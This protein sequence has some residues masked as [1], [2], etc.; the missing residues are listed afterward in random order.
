MMKRYF[1]YLIDLLI[2][3]SAHVK[4]GLYTARVSKAHLSKII[5]MNAMFK[6][7]Q[8]AVFIEK[9]INFCQPNHIWQHTADF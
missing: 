1:L 5:S 2:L 7:F 4:V 9:R 8:G 3:K 6:P